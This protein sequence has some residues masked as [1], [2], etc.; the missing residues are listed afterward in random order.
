VSDQRTTDQRLT[1]LE[2]EL[3]TVKE[4]QTAMRIEMNKRFDEADDRRDG[5]D[6]KLDKILEVVVGKQAKVDERLTHLE[7]HRTHPPIVQ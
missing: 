4:D 6:K 7:H 1:D 5:L 3:V 2:E